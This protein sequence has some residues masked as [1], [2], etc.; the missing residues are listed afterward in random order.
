MYSIYIYI[1]KSEGDLIK[2]AAAFKDKADEYREKGDVEG[3]LINYL[4]SA[5]NYYNVDDKDNLQ[6]CMKYIIPL[7]RKLQEYKILR[8][9]SQKNEEADCEDLSLE[10]KGKL[11]FDT[12]SGQDIAKKQLEMGLLYPLLYPRLFPYLSKGV[13]FYGPPGTGKTLLAKA[14]ANTLQ[15]KAEEIIKKE[16]EKEPSDI[17]ILFYAPSG[18]NLKGKYVGETEKNIEKYFTCASKK[19]SDCEEVLLDEKDKGSGQ[20]FDIEGKQK[21]YKQKSLNFKIISVIFLDEIEAIAGDRD[22]DPSG[23]M[24]NS[25]NTLLQMMDGVNS[26][27]N[28]VVMAATNKPWDLDP[29]ILRRFDTKIFVNPP[30]PE[31]TVKLIKTQIYQYLIASTGSLLEKKN[32]KAKETD[33]LGKNHDKKIDGDS[34]EKK[35]TCNLND[36][37]IELH[38]SLKKDNEQMTDD[39]YF[40]QYRDLYFKA[41]TDHEISSF[42]NNYL[43]PSKGKKDVYSGGDLKNICRYVFKM[44]GNLAIED[45]QKDNFKEQKIVFKEKNISGDFLLFNGSNMFRKDGFVAGSSANMDGER[46]IYL[47]VNNSDRIENA[48]KTTGKIVGTG[49]N[50]V[51]NIFNTVLP[52]GKLVFRKNPDAAYLKEDQKKI[53]PITDQIKKIN[54]GED[55]FETEVVTE[56]AAKQATKEATKEALRKANDELRNTPKGHSNMGGNDKYEKYID[57]FPLYTSL[58]SKHKDF[59]SERKVY[60]KRII[61]EVSC[62]IVYLLNTNPNSDLEIDYSIVIKE[63]ETIMKGDKSPD[64][65]DLQRSLLLFKDMFLKHPAAEVCKGVYVCQPD[66]IEYLSVTYFILFIDRTIGKTSVAEKIFTGINKVYGDERYEFF[67]GTTRRNFWNSNFKVKVLFKFDFKSNFETL[68]KMFQNTRFVDSNNYRYFDTRYYVKVEAPVC[69]EIFMPIQSMIVK[70]LNKNPRNYIFKG[71]DEVETLFNSDVNSLDMNILIQKK[72][73]ET[74]DQIFYYY[75]TEIISF[76]RLLSYRDQNDEIV[77]NIEKNSDEK[78]IESKMNYNRKI[79]YKIF[80]HDFALWTYE[81]SNTT[82]NVRSNICKSLSEASFII[83]KSGN[84]NTYN[85]RIFHDALVKQYKNYCSETLKDIKDEEAKNKRCVKISSPDQVSKI[86]NKLYIG[87]AEENKFDKVSNIDVLSLCFLLNTSIVTEQSNKEHDLI[88]YGE[89]GPKTNKPSKP[90]GSTGGNSR[91]LRK[92]LRK[93]GLR[94]NNYTMKIKKGGNKKVYT[95][96]FLEDCKEFDAKYVEYEPVTNPEKSSEIVKYKNKKGGLSSE[97]KASKRLQKINFNFNIEFFKQAIDKNNSDHIKASAN[98]DQIEE[99]YEYQKTNKAPS[100]KKKGT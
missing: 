28:V 70:N 13:L 57:F 93:G 96:K 98:P 91:K 8:N 75:A 63:L 69:N 9:R 29:A 49:V 99:F 84:E 56:E 46:A 37:K 26:F 65:D 80:R 2:Q 43:F 47:S 41:F 34:V 31:D 100:K 23:L 25:V 50:M 67:A 22:K 97:D 20:Y 21:I 77:K 17:R 44:M 66:I 68:M 42:V 60:I 30:N 3:S 27:D 73:N 61:K 90:D 12:V 45:S 7:Q 53:N 62:I 79:K 32:E 18:G 71:G 24:T 95:N 11:T 88:I 78:N 54:V 15:L 74:I 52:I 82:L 58:T 33:I 92:K 39:Q 10:S 35:A 55:Q 51:A 85:R 72:M 64:T 16:G 81:Y 19:A 4:L 48:W 1:M 5:N 40:D 6:E 83:T 59:E 87:D 36:P 38:P 14:F 94:K 89:K 76:N 86:T